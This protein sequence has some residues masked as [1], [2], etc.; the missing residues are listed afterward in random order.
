MGWCII[1]LSTLYSIFIN[2]KLHHSHSCSE[3]HLVCH[4]PPYS[5]CRFQ[6]IPHLQTDPTII[7]MGD[8]W[9]KIGINWYK[10]YQQYHIIYVVSNWFFYWLYKLGTPTMNVNHFPTNFHIGLF[11]TSFCMF[12]L[13]YLCA[14]PHDTLRKS[15]VAMEKHQCSE[16]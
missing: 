11:C 15:N 12:I 7:S 2:P 4:H 10:S 9:D 16:F 8:K 6:S 3:N 5:N 14:Y 13:R 1:V